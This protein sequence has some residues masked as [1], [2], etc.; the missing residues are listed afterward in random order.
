MVGWVASDVTLY[1]VQLFVVSIVTEEPS[2]GATFKFQENLP[3]TIPL[4]VFTIPAALVLFAVYLI[5]IVHS[6]LRAW[7]LLAE[8]YNWTPASITRVIL[9]SLG[10]TVSPYVTPL[11]L[12]E[13]PSV[14]DIETEHPVNA[15]EPW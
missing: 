7:L 1:R 10:V 4:T 12:N 15:V 13:Y 2:T 9:L 3:K 5:G 8:S 11:I 14:G 6:P